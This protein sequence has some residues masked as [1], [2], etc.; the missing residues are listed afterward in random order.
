MS[1]AK[2][3]ATTN[4]FVAQSVTFYLFCLNRLTGG[5]DAI[6]QVH[7]QG[8]VTQCARCGF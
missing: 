5:F 3:I 2:F 7:L 4:F 8:P 6:C 1:L